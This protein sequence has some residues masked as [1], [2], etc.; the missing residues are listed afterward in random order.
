[1]AK[2]WVLDTDTKGTGANMVP[3]ERVLDRGSQ[4]AR[5]V[6]FPGFSPRKAQARVAPAPAPRKPHEFRVIDVM[7]RQVLAERADARAT[8][9]ALEG[10]RSIVDITIYVWDPEH[11][12]WRMLTFGETQVLWEHRGRIEALQA[13]RETPPIQG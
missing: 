1:V 6:G 2:V 4:T 7:T 3:L 12:R 5:R 8:V 11:D 13:S 10:V 9:T